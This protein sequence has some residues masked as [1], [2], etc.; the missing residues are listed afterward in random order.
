MEDLGTV[1][2]VLDVLHLGFVKLRNQALEAGHQQMA[3]LA[4]TMEIIPVL[5]SR[6]SAADLDMIEWVLNNYQEVSQSLRLR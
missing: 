5:M 6:G 1:I 3:D 2:R 4:D